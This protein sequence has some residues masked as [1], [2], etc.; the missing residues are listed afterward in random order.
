VIFARCRSLSLPG[1]GVFGFYSFTPLVEVIGQ[2]DAQIT[3]QIFGFKW[4][5][6]LPPLNCLQLLPMPWFGVPEVC[7]AVYQEPSPVLAARQQAVL[8]S[9]SLFLESVP[10]T[11]HCQVLYVENNIQRVHL[12]HPHLFTP[13]L[14]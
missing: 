13:F 7:T 5:F 4:C 12:S 14:N 10:E 8:L 1:G 9:S 6:F 3:H 2:M 11:L